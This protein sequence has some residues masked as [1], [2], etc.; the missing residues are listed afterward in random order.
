MF[1]ILFLMLAVMIS[2]RAYAGVF[3]GQLHLHTNLSDA[4]GD[5]DRAARAYRELGF[6]FAAFSDHSVY[7]DPQVTVKEKPEGLLLIGAQELSFMCRNRMGTLVP[8]HANAIGIREGVGTEEIRESL[9]RQAEACVNDTL[10][11]GG[12]PML[13][14]PNF[15]YAYSF[16][17]ILH[18]TRPFLMEVINMHSGVPNEGSPA[19]PSHERIWDALLTS[20]KT[21]YGTGTDDTHVYDS[22]LRHRRNSPGMAWIMLEAAH[23]TEQDVLLALRNGSFYSTTGPEIL[24]CRMS[25]ERV[26][27][28]IVD[29]DP[30]WRIEFIGKYGM[31]LKASPGPEAEY[32]IKGDEMYVRVKAYSAG[33]SV[34]LTQPV[35]LDGRK[36]VI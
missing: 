6:D 36:T 14:H 29:A 20:G 12:I 23:L 26:Y 35:F 27:I 25:R 30:G 33:G 21:V 32:E 9:A 7:Y 3:K 15:R 4:D 22:S 8:F 11:A 13:N 18:I 2:G 24:D 19:F 10:A 1:V 34:L 16:D 5:P 28:S 31:L 17:E